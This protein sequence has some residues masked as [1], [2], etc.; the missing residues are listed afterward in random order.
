MLNFGPLTADIDWRVSH[1]GF[2]TAPTSLNA[3]QPDFPLGV[4]EM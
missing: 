3:G 2:V 4:S 1:L